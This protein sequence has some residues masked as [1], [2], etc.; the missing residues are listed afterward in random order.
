MVYIGLS[1]RRGPSILTA[2]K[3]QT[4]DDRG[5]GS[6]ISAIHRKTMVHMTFPILRGRIEGYKRCGLCV[7]C[8]VT[9]SYIY[10]FYLL[11]KCPGKIPNIQGIWEVC[12]GN[13]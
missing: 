12:P 1:R 3:P 6:H 11:I 7:V 9:I 13:Q 5:G 8:I 2:N 10:I 4:S